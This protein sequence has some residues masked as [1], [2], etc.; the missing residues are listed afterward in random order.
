MKDF[1]RIK[2][3]YNSDFSSLMK[4]NKEIK[5]ARGIN[6]KKVLLRKTI[7][8]IFTRPS[9]RTRVSF[10]VA[11]NEMDGNPIF[12]S[13]KELQL[14]KSETLEDI[15]KVLDIF[16]HGLIIRTYA[17]ND[18]ER[19]G[20]NTKFPVMNALTNEYH[21]CQAFAIFSQF[22]NKQMVPSKE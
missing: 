7:G 5:P 21:P 18:L 6:E 10:K 9:T 15:A 22:W 1:L 3:L 8:L 20:P 11:I 17:Q 14:G 19:F 2:D 16:L 4:L 12:L 13:H